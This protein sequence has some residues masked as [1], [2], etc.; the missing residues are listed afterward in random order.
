MLP[1]QNVSQTENLYRIIIII[2]LT[3]FATTGEVHHA[4]NL[5]KPKVIF[6]SKMTIERIAKVAKNN[7]FV[8]KIIALGSTSPSANIYT[9][10]QLMES[11]KIPSQD[12]FECRVANKRDDV[13]LIVCS[14]GTTGMPKGVQLSQSNILATLDSQL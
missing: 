2:L 1:I 3:T 4:I 13:A 6:A 10:S 11:K 12:T 9:L 14:S 7:S 8:K 5:S